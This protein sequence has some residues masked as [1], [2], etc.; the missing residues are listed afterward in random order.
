MANLLKLLEG[1]YCCLYGYIGLCRA[2]RE[3]SVSMAKNLGVSSRV[4]R[5]HWTIMSR[6]V[7]VDGVRLIPLTHQCQKKGVDCLHPIIAE[8][9]ATRD[10]ESK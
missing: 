5:Y 9:E 3:R 8:L 6:G 1:D 4:I 7:D 2:R 10:Q